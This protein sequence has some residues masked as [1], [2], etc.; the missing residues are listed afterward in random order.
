MSE[1]IVREVTEA[2]LPAVRS[3]ISELIKNIEE[4]ENI[5][6]NDAITNF[7]S[8]LNEKN[9]HIIVAESD[10]EV[11]GFL[12]F[13]TRQSILHSG[14]SGLVDELIVSE[15]YRAKGVG[16]KLINSAAEKCKSIGCIELEVSTESEN[17][18]A[19]AFYKELGFQERG[20]IFEFDIG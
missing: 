7:R 5:D 1:I 9:S 10:N 20:L 2:D 12:N 19:R 8:L 11:I 3:L 14:Q 18:A 13:T 4:K 15:K 17:Q 6:L 16:K